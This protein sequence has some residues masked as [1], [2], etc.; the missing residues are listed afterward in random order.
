[1]AVIGIT[2][3]GVGPSD[4]LLFVALMAIVSAWLAYRLHRACD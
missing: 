4:Q 1:M 2:A 3:L